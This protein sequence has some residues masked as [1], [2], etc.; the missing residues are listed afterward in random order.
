MAN[1]LSTAKRV[2]IVSALV[3][4]VGIRATARMANVSKDTVMKLWREIGEACIRYQDAT[5]R[6]LTCKRLQVDEIWSFVYAKAKNVPAEMRGTFGVGDVWT[7]TAIDADTKL[8]PSFLVGSRDSG[9]ATEFLQDL[10]GRLVNRVQLTTDGHKMY[11]GAVEDAF[12][13]DI[14]FA[15]LVKIYGNEATGPETRYSPAE[16]I[17]CEKK[18]VVGEPDPKHVSTSYVERANLTIWMSLRRFTRLTN[19]FSKKVENHTA[20]LG[21]FHAHYNLCRI[22]KSLRVTPAM[23]AGVESRVWQIADLVALLP[24]AEGKLRGPYRKQAEAPEISN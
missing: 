8:M 5:F 18:R 1:V 9:C 2:Q 16:C 15:Q 4:G 10:A 21:L 20:A 24:K 19:A 11:L 17:G 6:N 3:E 13:G 22:H 14:D 23:A 12:G 7:F